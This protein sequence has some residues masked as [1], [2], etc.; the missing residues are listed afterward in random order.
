[1][2]Q[3]ATGEKTDKMIRFKGGKDCQ[4]DID[5]AK[6]LT[7]QQTYPILYTIL[8]HIAPNWLFLNGF[9][10]GESDPA[11]KLSK[12]SSDPFVGQESI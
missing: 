5:R 8:I 3:V 11:S 2:N 10:S 4:G 7:S 12:H 9:G 6:T 1:M